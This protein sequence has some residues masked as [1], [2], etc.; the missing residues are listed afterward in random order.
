M[1]WRDH[2]IGRAE[3]CIWAGGEDAKV[4]IVACDVESDFGAFAAADPVFLQAF[5]RV[6]P[7]KVF[8]ARDK[9]VA[10]FGDTKHPLA[11]RPSL[12]WEAAPF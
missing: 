5:G 8:Q 1:L 12:H 7:V 2:H 10:I 3:K 11:D 4:C 9:F 6:G